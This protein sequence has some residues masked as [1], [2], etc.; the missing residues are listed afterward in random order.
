MNE[1][2]LFSTRNSVDKNK[3]TIK[4]LILKICLMLDSF[5][6]QNIFWFIQTF[7]N[8]IKIK[9]CF[10]RLQLAFSCIHYLFRYISLSIYMITGIFEYKILNFI[11]YFTFNNKFPSLMKYI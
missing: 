3:N 6:L 2:E 4:I 11:L 7:L 10:V 8:I 9:S 1:L 5:Y